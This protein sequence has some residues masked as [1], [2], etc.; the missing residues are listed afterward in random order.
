MPTLIADG[1]LDMAYNALFYRRDLTLPVRTLRQREDPPATATGG[2]KDSMRTSGALADPHAN[3]TCT[4]SLPQMRAGSVGLMLA[5]VMVRVQVSRGH[6]HNAARSQLQARARGIGHL[7]Y[8]QALQRLGEITLLT[9]P[10]ALH[11]CVRSW[12]SPSPD[13]PVGMILSMESADPSLGPE[14]VPFWREAGLRSVSL[15]H[16]GA[17]TYG[18]GTGTAGGLYPAGMR[19]LE[20]LGDT[21]IAIDLSHAADQTFWDILDHW[22]GPVHASHCNCRALQ[23]GQRHLSDDMIRAIVERGG[24]IGVV[25]AEPM[26][27]PEVD[28]DRW[29]QVRPPA[30]RPMR[31]A[32]EHVRHIAEVAGS[33]DHVAIGSD[34]DGGFG[35]EQSPVDLDTIADLQLFLEDAAGSGLSP[36]E[37]QHLAHRNLVRFFSEAW[38]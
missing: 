20:A 17:N 30:R 9:E 33:F 37:V 16:F 36:T 23:R 25:F 19:L 3:G 2:H 13:T 10:G 15:T 35:R 14:D 22:K 8:Y 1:H 4:V 26:L 32:L 6:N 29:P 28:F 31:A 11:N 7:A 34:L 12:Q 5:T 18:H 38:T 27:N 21:G 24:V